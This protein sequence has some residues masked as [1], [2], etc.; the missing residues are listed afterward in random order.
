MHSDRPILI[1]IFGLPGTGKTTFATVL[2]NQLGIKHFNTDIIRSLSG[3]SQQY[4]KENKALIYD[5]ILKLTSLEFE[6]GKSVIVDATFY[7]KKLRK[8][9]KVLAQEY[10]ASV[11]WIEVCAGEEVV[12]KRVS[13]KRRYSEADFAVYQMIKSQFEPMEEKYIQLFS[14]QEEMPDLIEKAIKFIKQ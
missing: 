3:K 9:F 1:V 2:S 8:R 13:K 11:K 5:E 7:K 10:D 12:K 6:K 4:D 14:G